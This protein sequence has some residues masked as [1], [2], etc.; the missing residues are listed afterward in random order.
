MLESKEE[1]FEGFGFLCS[2]KANSYRIFGR[3]WSNR[4]NYT[5]RIGLTRVYYYFLTYFFFFLETLTNLKHLAFQ[6]IHFLRWGV[7][8][9]DELTWRENW[10][11]GLTVQSKWHN[12]E[13]KNKNKK[14]K[15]THIHNPVWNEQK[16]IFVL[17]L[18]E[19]RSDCP[20]RVRSIAPFVNSNKMQ[21]YFITCTHQTGLRP[22]TRQ[23][24]TLFNMYFYVFER[25]VIKPIIRK[26]Y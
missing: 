19:G 4:N 13:K 1:A 8:V 6:S 12:G 2:F 10:L 25:E 9:A 24:C 7:R 5:V 20:F 17:D 22:E 14:N 23:R 16:I 3:P 11:T 18:N 15:H 21:I 26:L